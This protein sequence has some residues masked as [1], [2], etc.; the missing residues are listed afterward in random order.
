M[1]SVRDA[2]IL[3][4]LWL[5]RSIAYEYFKKIP[6]SHDYDDLVSVGTLGLIDAA[7][8]YKK[9]V[10]EFKPYANIRIKGA[11]VDFL[12]DEDPVSR[13][14]RNIVKEGGL[15]FVPKQQWQTDRTPFDDVNEKERRE[16]VLQ[17]IENVLTPH[18]KNITMMLYYED[19]RLVDIYGMG[20]KSAPSTDFNAKK[21]LKLDLK[22]WMDP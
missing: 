16:S 5:V 4:H 14:Q 8:K 19:V 6:R 12:R 13:R 22:K 15:L 2:L 17:A 1:H 18:E 21:K 3:D 7:N 20:I 10:G 11:I 9:A